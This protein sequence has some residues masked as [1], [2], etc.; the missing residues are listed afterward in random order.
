MVP[1]RRTTAPAPAPRAPRA[2]RGGR[3]DARRALA[4]RLRRRGVGHR[5]GRARRVVA[6]RFGARWHY[7]SVNGDSAGGLLHIT[8]R[9]G[10]RSCAAD[11]PP[12][13][14]TAGA[15]AGA[16]FTA[17]TLLSRVG[18]IFPALRGG[19]NKVADATAGDGP[20]LRRRGRRRRLRRSD[21]SP[22]WREPRGRRAAD[23]RD[24][25]PC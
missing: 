15:G 22:R 24:T 4:T 2:G 14:S 13:T 23:P 12:T 25:R 18:W 10:P 9:S 7:D 5:L 17:T 21:V 19:F 3:L 1:A 16:P 6:G 8:R 11:L 20:P